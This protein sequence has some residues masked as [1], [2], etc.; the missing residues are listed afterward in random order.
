LVEER[1]SMGVVLDLRAAGF[2]AALAGA[3]LLWVRFLPTLPGRRGGRG[4][5]WSLALVASAALVLHVTSLFLTYRVEEVR[6]R[7]GGIEL[8]GSLHLPRRAG[9]AVPALVVVHGSGRQ[10]RKEPA[11]F[12]RLFARRGFAALAYD[13]RGSGA[14]TGELYEARYEDLADDAVAAIELLGRRPGIDPRRIGI[15]GFS[16]AEWVAAVAAAGSH[17][18]AF[19]TIVSPS[20]RSPAEQV[21]YELEASLRAEGFDEPTVSRAALL[22]RRLLEYQRHATDAEALRRD[23]AAARTEPWFGPAELPGELYAPEDYAWWRA[24]M[25][26]DPIPVWRRVACPVLLVS[27]GLDLK[28]PVRDSQDRIRRALL[29]GGNSRFTGRVFDAAGHGLVEWWLPGRLPPPRFPRGYPELLAEWAREQVG[30]V[31][32]H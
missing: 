14:S 21:A 26:F 18:L 29:E 31:K 12:A 23:L 25:D 16:E 2:I 32:P 20:G 19:L 5:R 8:A 3:V 27:G 6:F 1:S 9:G 30:S 11:F 10:T 15:L 28:S 22:N 13:K 24:V 7:S 4:A 17:G